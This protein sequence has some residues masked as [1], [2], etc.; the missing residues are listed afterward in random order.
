MNTQN[1]NY[2]RDK[3]YI[4]SNKDILN[5][6]HKKSL[7]NFIQPNY[8]LGY[9]NTN[10]ELYNK[11]NNND[12]NNINNSE[13]KYISMINNNNT[14]NFSNIIINS[15][16]SSNKNKFNNKNSNFDIKKLKTSNSNNLSD[17]KYFRRMNSDSRKFLLTQG[18]N[19]YNKN[20]NN[21]IMSSN[22]KKIG[23]NKKSKIK[24][25][26]L[27][28]LSIDNNS[29]NKINKISF[30]DK[31]L[32]KG[33]KY[34][35]NNNNTYNNLFLSNKSEIKTESNNHLINNYKKNFDVMKKNLNF[36][37]YSQNSIKDLRIKKDK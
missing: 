14:N 13:Y 33:E 17:L 19:N 9:P 37:I 10:L 23:H 12:N 2:L 7:S 22:K 35:L 5:T 26:K 20:N 34:E 15:N 16:N 27:Q 21:L 6:K 29:S 1:K 28:K 32:H 8:S 25:K 24:N 11:I 36:V 18:D 4:K 30:I 3:K 31:I